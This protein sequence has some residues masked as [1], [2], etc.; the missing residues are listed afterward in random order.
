MFTRKGINYIFMAC[1]AGFLQFACAASPV[2]ADLCEGWDTTD[3]VLASMFG[4]VLATDIVQTRNYASR[5]EY[6]E[7]NP[8]LSSDPSDAELA[9]AFVSAASFYIAV[10]CLLSKPNR[11]WWG[12][13]WIGVEAYVVWRNAV[14]IG[15]LRAF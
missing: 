9:V 4:A 7:S 5:R 6:Q 13:L 1:L 14:T 11:E 15:W 2:R 3:T 8:A 10:A 12:T